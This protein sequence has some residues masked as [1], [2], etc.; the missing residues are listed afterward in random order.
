VSG[1]VAAVGQVA[2]CCAQLTR[3]SGREELDWLSALLFGTA[4]VALLS[5]FLGTRREQRPYE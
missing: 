2:L 5:G 4:C 1:I 3:H